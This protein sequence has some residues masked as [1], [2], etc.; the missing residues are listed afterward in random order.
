MERK[1]RARAQLSNLCKPLFVE[2][3]QICKSNSD[4]EGK[5]MFHAYIARFTAVGKALPMPWNCKSQR[6][7]T[8]IHISFGRCAMR[9]RQSRN[10]IINSITDRQSIDSNSLPHIEIHVANCQWGKSIISTTRWVRSDGCLPFRIRTT[11]S[12]CKSAVSFLYFFVFPSLTP[13]VRQPAVQCI[14]F[15]IS[16]LFVRHRWLQSMPLAEV[17]VRENS[18]CAQSIMCAHRATAEC[19]Q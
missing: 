11:V 9:C 8:K 16:M 18:I 14:R 7:S 2:C 5:S 13:S 6:I 12:N 4:G 3:A 15:H 10:Q 17:N 19:R 1:K